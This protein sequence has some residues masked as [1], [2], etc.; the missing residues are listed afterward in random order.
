MD[1]FTPLASLFGGVLIG[2]S[3]VALMLLNGR[4]AGISGITAGLLSPSGW[5]AG[6]GWRVAFVVG[7]IAAP[8]VLVFANTDQPDIAFV[9]SLPVMLVAGF[10]VG[11]GT[12]LSNGC[13]S[14]HGIC[15]IARLSPRSIVA[16]VVFMAAGVL[17]TF[18]VRHM[19]AGG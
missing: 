2:L 4:I 11:F 18:V 3:A 1:H 14:G 16:T 10:L 12:V 5:A 15:G 7:L 9:V 19:I 17:T 13:T 6:Q 8:L